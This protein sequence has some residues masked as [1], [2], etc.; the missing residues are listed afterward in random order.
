MTTTD[1]RVLHKLICYCSYLQLHILTAKI[2]LKLG[3]VLEAFMTIFNM[4]GMW[5]FTQVSVFTVLCDL[6]LGWNARLIYTSLT[7]LNQI[8]YYVHFVTEQSSANCSSSDC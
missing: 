4:I 7:I 6:S 1:F 8:K 2:M 5:E 3:V